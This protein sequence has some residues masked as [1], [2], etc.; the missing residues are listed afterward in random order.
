MLN[1]VGFHYYSG[2]SYREGEK[3]TSETCKAGAEKTEEQEKQEKPGCIM[4]PSNAI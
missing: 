2:D 4:S 1:I 3:L